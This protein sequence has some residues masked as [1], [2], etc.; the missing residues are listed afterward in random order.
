MPKTSFAD[1]MIDWE[2]LLASAAAN[3]ED[4]PHIDAYRQQLEVETAGAKAA[5][6]RQ[7]SLSAEVQQATRD[8]EGFLQRGADLAT[9]MRAGIRT[10]Y[11]NRAEKLTE[12]GMKPFRKR[13]KATTI[14]KPPP[15]VGAKEAPQAATATETPQ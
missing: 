9:R 5:S 7:A 3:K 14:E 12:F 6:L 10:K 13:K 15:Q 1:L 2:K 11:G 8:L 4:L